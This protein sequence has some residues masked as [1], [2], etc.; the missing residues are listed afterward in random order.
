MSAARI[1][2][3][4]GTGVVDLGL[5]DPKLQYRATQSVEVVSLDGGETHQDLLESK[6]VPFASIGTMNGI[7]TVLLHRHA[8][9]TPPHLI[10]HY[11]NFAFLRNWG[12]DAVIAL[13][14]CGMLD[15]RNGPDG[16]LNVGD[17]VLINDYI[18][19]TGHA[20]PPRQA[21]I[22]HPSGQDALNH[23][24]IH[25]VANAFHVSKLWVRQSG[26]MI[27]IRG[28]RF[29]TNAES[30]MYRMMG[31]NLINMTTGAETDAAL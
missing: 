8:G 2:I 9:N 10:D 20:G 18:D 27:S 5:K 7:D 22:L 19:L 24:V 4:G 16:P 14:A 3:I 26:T 28:P 11:A 12:V 1:G 29:A 31:A 17:F 30:N 23:R 15:E 21:G 6:A 13:T 25:S